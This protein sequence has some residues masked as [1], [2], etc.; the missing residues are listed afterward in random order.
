[1]AHSAREFGL[2]VQG[3]SGSEELVLCPF[4]SDG[5]ASAWFSPSK[6]LFY[7]SVC[8]IGLNASQLS[9]KLGVLCLDDQEPGD[10]NLF[11]EGNLIPELELMSHYSE[12][13]RER[14]VSLETAERFGVRWQERPAAAVLPLTTARGRVTGVAERYVDSKEQGTRYRFHGDRPPLWPL[15]LLPEQ[16][17]VLYVTEGGWSAMRMYQ[18][19]G[20]N[21][22]ALLGARANK[23][24]AEVVDGFRTIFLYDGDLAGR[25]ACEKMMGL[26]PLALCFTVQTSPDD[27]TEAQIDRLVAK[28]MERI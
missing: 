19:A 25:N 12:Y 27:M 15:H 17:Q 21:C 18:R 22:L 23:A 10:Y 20:V 28:T 24:I 11:A 5:K 8:N 1:V 26:A 14:G 13:I 7:C 3:T 6:G 16:G 2:V 4:H 9:E